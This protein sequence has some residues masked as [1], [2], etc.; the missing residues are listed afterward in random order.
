MP[1]SKRDSKPQSLEDAMA[2]DIA[3]RVERLV[4]MVNAV[5]LDDSSKR[6]FGIMFCRELLQ[7]LGYSEPMVI[8]FQRDDGVVVGAEFSIDP[9]SDRADVASVF[10]TAMSGALESMDVILLQKFD[11][12]VGG[13]GALADKL[14]AYAESA[15]GY[16]AVQPGNVAC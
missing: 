2:R 14:A 10:A 1:K 4:G 8:E 13:I 9:G 6:Q 12:A 16:N 7:G 3:A 5:S 11:T 15:D